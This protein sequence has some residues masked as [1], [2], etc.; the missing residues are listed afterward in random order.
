MGKE[1]SASVIGVG[2]L[3]SAHSR[4]LSRHESVHVN[5]VSD[6]REDAGRGIAHEIGASFYRDYSEMLEKETPDLAVVATQDAFHREA[7]IA[8]A[9]AGIPNIIVEKP[10][11]T[12]VEDAEEMIRAVEK[13]GARLFVNYANRFVPMDMAT[14][15]VIQNGLIGRPVYGEVRLDDN[16]SVPTALWGDRSREWAGKSS[17]AHFLLTHVLDLILWYFQPVTVERVFAI[18]QREVLKFTP[19]LYDVFLFFD[20]GMKIRIKAEWIKH[21]EGLVEFYMCF[22][23]ED[24]TIIYNKLPGYG[25]QR[26]WRTNI[27]SQL[28]A[29]VLETHQAEL[30]DKGIKVQIMKRPVMQGREAMPPTALESCDWEFYNRNLVGGR[31]IDSIGCMVQGILEDTDEPSIWKGFGGLPN[32]QDGLKATKIVCAIEKSA[33]TGTEAVVG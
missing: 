30:F 1:L 22:D 7:V 23:G 3:G 8:C 10:L 29:N 6:I 27:G 12:T 18:S 26:G 19:D 32:G 17:T 20:T 13:S 15:Y 5:A 11:A 31:T 16:I 2:L 25:V 21:M 9:R 24:G 14:R 33:E 28:S 4:T